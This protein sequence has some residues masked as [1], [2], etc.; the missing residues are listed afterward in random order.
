MEPQDI[1]KHYSTEKDTKRQ[2]TTHILLLIV[3]MV[4]GE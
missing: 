1:R 2:N 4:V 3:N